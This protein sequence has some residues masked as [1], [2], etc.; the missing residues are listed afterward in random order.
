MSNFFG[1]RSKLFPPT[2]KEH[3]FTL[4]KEA[5]DII[6]RL[7]IRDRTKRLGAQ[8]DSVEI[9]EQKFFKGVNKKKI[10][11]MKFKAP[12]IPAKQEIESIKIDE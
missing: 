11:E 6:S 4:S 12:L 10:L 7:L 9:L 1:C 5:Q 2:K 8:N 3:G